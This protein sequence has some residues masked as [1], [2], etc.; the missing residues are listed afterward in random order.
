M[1]QW[2]SFSTH[3]Y[4]SFKPKRVLEKQDYSNFGRAVT[5]PSVPVFRNRNLPGHVT[6]VF[7]IDAREH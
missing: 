5:N 1:A 6:F 4:T 7:D 3:Q 2:F